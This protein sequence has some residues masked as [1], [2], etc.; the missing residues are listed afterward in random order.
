DLEAHAVDGANGPGVELVV[1]PQVLHREQAHPSLLRARRGLRTSFR[2]WPINVNERTSSMMHRPGAAR[3]QTAPRLAA[4]AVKGRCSISPH[5]GRVRSPSPRKES[6]A[7]F[8]IA[9]ATTSTVFATTS[10]STWGSR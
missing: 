5:D 8:R 3:Y 1:D 9:I 4:P 6:V 2:A 10:G 7:S